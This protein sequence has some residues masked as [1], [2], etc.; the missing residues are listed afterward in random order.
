[1]KD[2]KIEHVCSSYKKK[3]GPSFFAMS[4]RNIITVTLQ[5]YSNKKT[6]MINQQSLHVA[7][8]SFKLKFNIRII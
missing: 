7:K 4:A 2:L 5:C 8:K 1:M 6:E 3:N